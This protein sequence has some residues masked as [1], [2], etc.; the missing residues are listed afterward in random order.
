MWR[1]AIVILTQN[2]TLQKILACVCLF[3]SLA[4]YLGV[5]RSISSIRMYVEFCSFS[6]VHCW[7]FTKWQA[8]NIRINFMFWRLT[9]YGNKSK[10]L[11]SVKIIS[12]KYM[13]YWIVS[14]LNYF[15]WNDKLRII[16]MFRFLIER[17][18]NTQIFTRRY[19]FKATLD[20][21]TTR[22]T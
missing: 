20:Q 21:N 11:S 15:S 2:L 10:L 5:S 16:K 22:R 1:S 19:T 14:V 17:N 18:T 6:H 4:L 12:N 7:T 9:N 13:T 3:D 8:D